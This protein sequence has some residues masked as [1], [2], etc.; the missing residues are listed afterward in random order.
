MHK[1]MTAVQAFLS[2]DLF[3]PV[4]SD[5]DAPEV[6]AP[7]GD[8]VRGRVLEE[9]GEKGDD[10]HTGVNNCTLQPIEMYKLQAWRT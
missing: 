2:S 9:D 7:E 5:C 3:R 10:R 8:D 1:G 4:G 6:P